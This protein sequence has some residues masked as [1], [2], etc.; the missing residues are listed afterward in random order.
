MGVL[1]AIP[2]WLHTG[3]MRVWGCQGYGQLQGDL[4][5]NITNMCTVSTCTLSFIGKKR[6]EKKGTWGRVVSETDLM[7]FSC[8]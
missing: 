7:L 3:I 6:K 5:L 8:F 1:S 2:A 4:L